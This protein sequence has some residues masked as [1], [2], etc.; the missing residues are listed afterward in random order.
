MSE[1]TGTC[2]R[3][4]RHLVLLDAV[5]ALAIPALADGF[6]GALEQLDDVLFDRAERVGPSQLEFLDAMRELRRRRDEVA[7][8]FRAHLVSTW[9][10]FEAGQP[11]SAEDALADHADDLTLVTEQQLESRLAVRNLVTALLRDCK[12]VLAR[13]DRRLGLIGGCPSLDADHNPIGPEHLGVAVHEAFA[14]C[15]LAMEVR[16]VVI[17]LCE[18]HLLA[19]VGKVYDG[20]DQHLHQAGVM[21]GLAGP[22]TVARASLR[23]SASAPATSPV[24]ADETMAEAEPPVWA[25]RFMQR[26]QA[27]HTDALLDRDAAG[28]GVPAMDPGSQ[29]VLLEALHHL[30]QEV[31]S[32]RQQD[33]PP[34]VDTTAD[35]RAL[36]HRE[37]MSVLSLLQGAP[38]ANL[39]AALGEEGESLSQ[40]LKS[41]VLS[42]ATQLGVDPSNAR[43][44]SGDEDA[45]DLVGMLFDV[46]LDERDLEGRS[47]D[48]IGRLVV[49]FV[50]VALLDRHM[51]VQK[52]H[53]AR[54]LLNLLAEACEGCGGESA[55]E[56]VLLGKVEEVVE[57]LIA[58]FNENLAIFQTL[59]EEFR[60]FLEQ[61][62]RRI[63]IAERR[64][65]EIQRGQERLEAARS[66]MEFE[67]NLRLDG[68]RLPQAIEDFM[69]HP[70]SHHITMTL[71]REGEVGEGLPDALELADGLLE[72]VDEAR[73]HIVGKPWLQAL[74]PALLRVFASVGVSGDAA[75][76]AVEALHDTLQAVAAAR[77]DLEK[78]LPELPHVALPGPAPVE[79]SPAIQLVAGTDTLDFDH[80]DADH[81]RALPIGSWLDFID[82]D[83]RVQA[84]KLSWI[85]PISRRLLFVNRRGV[86]FCVASPEELAAMVR[87]GRL[88]THVD[89][90][91]FDSAMQ[92]VINRLDPVLQ[93]QA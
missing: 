45:I 8:R 39:R 86:R 18:R 70:W 10:A 85:S 34:P 61:H 63:E 53:P 1:H 71:L 27:T 11:L 90:D 21:P 6:S 36:S 91:A 58:E 57:R 26:M 46:M 28:N 62:R 9:Q 40:R 50:K 72:E 68:R 20:I 23:S 25:T 48:L 24:A 74:R 16:L 54:R 65:T 14:T 37:M 13:L 44:A 82:K 19:T 93:A 2:E 32:G 15:D 12:P 52:T 47:R 78:P 92:G 67:L 22:G 76:S 29:G 59:E 33:A 56:R 41:E 31:R 43:L 83:N 7:Q 80:A 79:D 81:F 51:F 88:R 73:R 87:L 42:G 69:R 77:P 75:E 30:L 38:S 17:K 35:R 84:G 5:S 55:A 4:G 3:V 89:E 66:R 49:P 60:G 64:A